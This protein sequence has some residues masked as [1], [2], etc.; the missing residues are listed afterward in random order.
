MRKFSKILSVLLAMVLV[1]SSFSIGAEA[2]Y[3]AYKDSAI[4][5]YDS[6]DKPILTTEQYGSMAL[7]EVDRMLAE[8]NMLINFDLA[9]LLTIKA[10]ITSVDATLLSLRDLWKEVEPLLSVIGG[11]VRYLD[12]SSLLNAPLRTDEGYTDLDIVY[13]L[14]QF[15]ADNAKIVG[16]VP[17]G[18]VENGGLDLGILAGFVDIE[19]YLNLPLLAKELVAELV[20]P[21]VDE[22]DLDLTLTLDE[23]VTTFI[24]L[25]ASGNY[26][27]EKSDTINKI[28][29]YIQKYVPG[30]EKE[31]DLLNDSFYDIVE[32]GVRI[33]INSVGVPLAN[34]KLRKVLREL[35]GV[36]YTYLGKDEN[37]DRMY[38]EDDSNLN[39]YANLINLDFHL[40]EYDISGWGEESFVEHLND[41]LGFVAEAA[42]NPNIDITWSYENGNAD[43]IPNIVKIAKEVLAQTGDEFFAGYVEVLDKEALDKMTDDEFAAYLLRSTV[44]GS[45]DDVFVPNTCTTP[46]SV[47]FYTMK[48]IAANTVPSQDYSDVEEDL[49]GV[50]RMLLDMGAYGLNQITNM[51]MEYGLSADEFADAA[52]SWIVEN[53]GGFV[54]DVEGEGW[55]ALS[56]VIFSIIPS[57]WL[58]YTEDGNARDNL[59]NILFEDVVEN[60]LNLDL[61]A[62]L[63]LLAK[64]PD[65]ELNGTIIEVLLGRIVGIIN[66][67]IPGVFPEDHDYS[68]LEGLLD[69]DFLSALLKNLLTGLND[70][71]ADLAVSLLPLLCSILDLS[72]PAEFGYPYISLPETLDPTFVDSFYMFNESNGINTNATDKYGNTPEEPDQ[73]YKY[74]IRSVDAT[75]YNYYYDM[76][77]QCYVKEELEDS[78]SVY[79]DSDVFINGG[80][81][82]TF[83]FDGELVTGSVLK[84]VITYDVYEESGSQMTKEPLTATCYSY[85]SSTVDDGKESRKADA[86][87]QGNLHLVYYDNAKYYQVG[88]K[89][90]ELADVEMD[91]QRNAS[92]TKTTHT[93]P[94]FFTVDSVTIDDTLAG[95]GIAGNEGYEIETYAGGGVQEYKP[96]ISTDEEAILEE[97][98]YTNTFSFTATATQDVDETINF[99]QFIYVY[100]DYGLP[101]MVESA[102][103]SDRQKSSYNMDEYETSYLDFGTRY[104]ILESDPEYVFTEEDETVETVYGEDVWAE[105]EAALEDAISIAFQPRDVGQFETTHASRYFEAAYAL[106]NAIEKLEDGAISSGAAGVKATLESFV[107]DDTYLV[108]DENGNPVLDEETDLPL[109]AEY[110]YDDPRHTYF[111][112][113]DYIGYTYSNFKEEKEDAEDI[114]DLWLA[115]GDVESIKAAYAEHRLNL[116]G[117]R[118]IRVRAY[119]THLEAEI[120]LASATY[121]A[122]QGNYSDESWEAFTRAY[123]FAQTVAAEPIGEVIDGSENLEGDGLRQT[124]VN[125]ARSQ[126]IASRK[127]LVEGTAKVDYTQLNAAINDAKATYDAGN[128]AGTYTSLSWATF[129][130]AYEEA[131]ALVEQNLELSDE[132]QAAV[133]SAATALTT[134]YGDL[135]QAEAGGYSF[136]EDTTIQVYE[137]DDGYKY[138]VGLDPYF[139]EVECYVTTTGSYWAEIIYNEQGLEST[140]AVLNIYDGDVLVEEIPI[141]WFGDING[142]AAMDASDISLIIETMN[143]ATEWADYMPYET[144]EGFATDVNFDYVMDASDIAVLIDA[145][146]TGALEQQL[147]Y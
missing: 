32:K 4:T 117:N 106:Y 50:I 63:G 89:A 93:L 62:F 122:G 100:N 40:E 78:V 111:G 139:P 135:E 13:A 99:P 107:P 115:G 112:R 79:P 104:D 39:G 31:I 109:K 83:E 2:A 5:S 81:S 30:I 69:A 123:A 105:Y 90:S 118:L 20:W 91:L 45:I 18:S 142:D 44:N 130:A 14:F 38:D 36:E 19:E 47:L 27:P 87:A 77:Q 17:Y 15:L 9:G 16:K 120:A 80:T 41:I 75:Q 73:L 25:V 143:Y 54:S 37:G 121:E 11:D 58:P 48:S 56:Y 97:G 21:N 71:V 127:R 98:I 46:M 53:Y 140:A 26:D 102:V 34:T 28:S 114:I 70:R 131:V 6:V 7:D 76:E 113:E 86:N 65:G 125:E 110:D 29:G 1:F 133:N 124:K 64:N 68:T 55:E 82:Q 51:N 108:T 72:S 94:A 126:L 74:Y 24:N 136:D 132:N 88:T 146:M 137:A 66:Y 12:V 3:T 67:V 42:I 138:V 96:Y 84:V 141:V 35:C 147:P 119:T 22:D 8:E 33:A 85:V 10:D 59:Y 49:D 129:A 23:Y 103:A 134:A 128:D 144:A 116:Y 61:D 92:K 101:K 52:M 145:M 60:I 57:D 95:L 43:I